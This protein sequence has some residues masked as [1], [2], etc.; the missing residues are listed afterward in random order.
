MC[1]LIDSVKQKKKPSYLKHL[2]KT[3]T[4]FAQLNLARSLV[5][6]EG[7]PIAD[8]RLVDFAEIPPSFGV[9]SVEDDKL[10]LQITL[11]EKE[12]PLEVCAKL[13]PLY[14]WRIRTQPAQN[15]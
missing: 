5:T 8:K 7:V 15:Q 4:A 6:G 11:S 14:F 2:P 12:A 3:P 9:V 10:L 13:A 1:A